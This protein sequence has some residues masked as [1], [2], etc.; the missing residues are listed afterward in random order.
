[1]VTKLGAV[2]KQRVVVTFFGVRFAIKAIR[3]FIGVS[4]SFITYNISFMF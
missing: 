4:P 3:V 1:M 2:T